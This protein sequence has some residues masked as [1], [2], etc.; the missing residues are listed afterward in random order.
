MASFRGS[1]AF[2][3][4]VIGL[5]V[6]SG[7]GA[8]VSLAPTF[9]VG[10]TLA[11]SQGS[12]L[13][14]AAATCTITVNSETP[15]NHAVQL[16]IDTYG[17]LSSAGFPITI[18]LG[19]NTFPEQLTIANTTD[20]TISGA[21]NAS[22]FLAPTTASPNQID[23]DSGQAIDALIGAS[24]DTGLVLEDFAVVG[25]SVAAE[26]A[27]SCGPGFVGVYYGNSSGSV[28]GL[29]VT[30]IN[31]DAGCQTQMGVLA[32][33]GYFHTGFDVPQSFSVS[34]STVTGSGKNGITCRD[35]GLVCAITDNTVTMTPMAL[36]YAA[37]NGIELW[38][39]SGTVT[40]N[41]VSGSWYL[42]GNCADGTY[43]TVS[44]ACAP[45][46]AFAS[47]ILLLNAAGSLNASA[48]RLS[49]DQ[50]GIWTV[51]NAASV[52]D[53]SVTGG[54]FGVL[55][56]NNPADGFGAI[57]SPG[58]SVAGGNAV[59]NA[60]V[61][62]FAYDTNVS[63]LANIVH[64]SNVSFEDEND[65]NA[66]YNVD[67]SGNTGDAN[68]S[69]AL[70]G[71][72]SSFQ[73]G[74]T[75][76][77][78]V[79]VF[80]LSDNSFTNISTAPAGTPSF[81]TL[82]S[83]VYASVAGSSFQAFSEGLAVVVQDNATVLENIVSAPVTASAGGGIYVFADT[84]F[85]QSNSVTGYSYAT[86][87][88]WWPNS[89]AWGIFLQAEGAATLNRNVLVDDAIGI[90]VSSSVYGAFPAPSWPFVAPAS[91]GP[92]TVSLNEV[93][94]STAFGIAFE[95][96]QNTLAEDATP[97]VSVL[98]NTV[99][100]TATGAVGMMLDQGTY[101][102]SGNSF[103]GTTVT[104]DSGP[105]QP[106]GVGAID[107]ASVQVLDAYDSVTRVLAGGNSF[108]HTSVYYS[109]LNLTSN[110]PFYASI[111]G[112]PALTAA[113]MPVVSA[114]NLD[115]D[116]ALTV[117][118]SLPTTGVPP[119]AWTWMVSSN[120]GSYSVET[121]CAVSTGTNGAPGAAVACAITANSLTPGVSYTF[122]L[123]VTDSGTTPA[124]QT[125]S[126]S[127]PVLVATPL[128][129]PSTPSASAT[130]LD[131]DQALAVTGAIPSTG[132]SAYSWQWL[133]SVNGGSWVNA[134]LCTANSGSGASG[135][136]SVSCDV[137]GGTLGTGNT[138]AFEL[139]VTD[140]AGETT[141]SASSATVTVYA[142]LTAPAAPSV[143]AT[144]LDVNQALT[145]T[146]TL[147]SNGAPPI[148]WA[149]VVSVNGGGFGA[150]TACTANSGSSAPG[151]LI[152]CTVPVS[153]LTAGDTYE[154][155][156]SVT[157]GATAPQSQTS[158]ASPLVA[159]ATM[160]KAPGA[161]TVNRPALDENQILTVSGHIPMTGS[162][163]YSWAWLV[164]INSGS[165]VAMSQCN[166]NG[167]SGAAAGALEQC[168]IPA[169][170]LSPGSFYNF[171]LKVTDGAT[172]AESKT[173]GSSLLTVTVA[174]TL[175]A[176]AAP[177]VS[178]TQLDVNQVLTVTVHLPT[179]GTAPYGW[180]WQ[181]SVNAG[182]FATAS[183]C[184]APTG[185]G[186]SS[187][188]L[189]TCTVAANSL[190]V[191]DHYRFRLVSTDSATLHEKA[192]SGPSSTVTVHTALGTAAVPTLAYRRLVVSQTETVTGKIPTGGTSADSWTWLVSVN[193]GSYTTAGQ[194][195]TS[196]GSGAAAGV[197]ET[198][199][200]AGGT[201]TVGDT[202][203]FELQVS[204][205]ASSPETTTSAPSATVTVVA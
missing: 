110:P 88:G 52:W 67:L 124:T 164:S 85:L 188:A 66:P 111:I 130:V 160:L 39:A 158:A 86:G 139:T 19:A 33:T 46:D 3:F 186:G 147:Q 17:P 201:L 122:E 135:G 61:G 79:G 159:V 141:T 148:Q 95:L 200:I 6:V 174:S 197:T 182:V 98:G 96:N 116:Q 84:A 76:V 58:S 167:G 169:N 198:C 184:A 31:N 125:T 114:S 8:I 70:L 49:G 117:T 120:G 92:I 137:N 75:G 203:H 63:F 176:S 106:T 83:G 55:F 5:F 51:D 187:G 129:G 103:N 93:H 181:V 173:S 128:S 175:A 102:V 30:D 45:N 190:T 119:Y 133:V 36:N 104:G 179:S 138:Y 82:V 9:A 109:L 34:S 152:T 127:I 144:A 140:A 192:I 2:A 7:A 40:G 177:T 20:L 101:T 91:A 14:T 26:L 191:G 38:G 202:Y 146:A 56:D 71:D 115:S 99:D 151:S 172:H 28:S 134:A 166:V 145:V 43:F 165:F 81:G 18:C 54:I 143:S 23:W 142:A 37:T 112:Q 53:N 89:Q 168:V 153:T 105:S 35:N 180:T 50:V 12:S 196:G 121:Q 74:S 94:N 123:E 100:N 126:P 1:K 69:G 60:N 154:F 21:G 161:P 27:G 150:S 15:G 183:V 62:L 156:I 68:V 22:T 48:N 178:S 32:N 41:W 64:A 194:C 78:P 44:V 24:N 73:N 59:Q 193:G 25:T 107:T 4:V 87:P 205:S 204:D 108:A 136:Q 11:A 170:T 199:A 77:L 157:D 162:V 163:P 29:T 42:P 131:D 118:S 90:A 16:A 155:A 171:E 189:V 57:F 185:S 97:T 195:S 10:G 113:P 149:W 65:I 80:S 13:A 72:V 132:S 47:G